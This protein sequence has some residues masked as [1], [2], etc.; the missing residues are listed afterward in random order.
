MFHKKSRLPP[1]SGG[2]VHRAEIN[3]RNGR[4]QRGSWLFDEF[5]ELAVMRGEVS[6]LLAYLL[7][8]FVPERQF[9]A[10][11]AV[12]VHPDMRMSG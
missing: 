11:G 4:R 3:A 10:S 7:K 1:E 2:Q 12:Y 5:N 9:A 6:H 8:L